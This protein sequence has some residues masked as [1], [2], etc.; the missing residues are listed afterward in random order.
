MIKTEIV[1]MRG[2]QFQRT[3]SDAGVL[4]GCTH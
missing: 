4:D 2:T 3:G 1:T